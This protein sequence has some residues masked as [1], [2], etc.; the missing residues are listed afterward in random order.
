MLLGLSSALGFGLA[1]LFGAVSTRRLGVPQTILIIQ[2][3]SATVLS[4]LL[5]T[6]VVGSLSPNFG[7]RLA[8]AAGGILG[9]V[10]YFSFFRALQLGPVAIVSPVFACYATVTVTLS[11]A[12]NGERLSALAVVGIASTIGGVALASARGGSSERSARGGG[13]P[14]ALLA[15]IAWGV[16]SYLLGR[17]AQQTGWFYPLYGA[18]LA[19]LAGALVVAVVLAARG[20]LGAVPTG[21]SVLIA[22]P[23]GWRTMSGS[24]PS[25]AAAR[26]AWCRSPRPSRRASR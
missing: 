17:A 22:S 6:P 24:P 11:L 7:V 3:L 23:R 16:A 5:L 20:A 8:I 10:S 21:R 15:M 26:S 14:F 1:D 2:A 13:I 9:I 18:R 25:S 19:E 12:L 4:L